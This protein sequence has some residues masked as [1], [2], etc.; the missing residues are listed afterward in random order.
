MAG[1]YHTTGETA[2]RGTGFPPDTGGGWVNGRG[3]DSMTLLKSSAHLATFF[4]SFNWWSADPRNDLVEAPALCLADP[5]TAYAIHLPENHKTNIT[6]EGPLSYRARWFNPRT[7]EW[8]AL[9]DA[10]GPKWQTPPPP[11][12]GDWALLLTSYDWRG[13]GPYDSIEKDGLQYNNNRWAGERGTMF[14][15]FGPPAVTWW[16]THNGNRREFPVSEPNVAIG[17]NWGHTTQ[18]SPLPIRLRDIETL[19]VSWSVTLPPHRDDQMYRVYFQFFFSDSPTGKYNAGDF[20]PTLY[21]VNCPANF[22]AKDAGMRAIAGNDW[23]ICDSAHSS[24]MGRYIVPLLTPFLKPDANRVI[25]VRDLD[26]KA[27]ID[28]HIA[29]GFYSPDAYCMTVHASWEVWVLDQQLRTNDLA[30][31][32]KKKGEPAVTIPAWSTLAKPAKPTPDK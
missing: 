31:T 25:E 21:A 9:P 5:G 32:I 18:G 23:H 17:S 27:L 26:L 13:T 24:N 15:R 10:S 4:T 11:G 29:Q 28:D 20:A 12:A 30:F 8:I 3:D 22:W 14:A 19:K 7:G 6:L 1:G 2:N 16:T